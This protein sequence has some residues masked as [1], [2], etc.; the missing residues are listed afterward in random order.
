[1]AEVRLYVE[2]PLGAGQS[3]PLTGD[4]AHYLFA[5]MRMTVGAELRVFN[6]REGEW[7][8]R[9]ADAGR[10]A[11]RLVCLHQTRPLRLPPDLWLLFAPLKKAR[12]DFVVEKATELGVARIC[13]VRTDFTAAERVRVDRLRA[14]AVEATEQCGGT[15]VPVVEDLVPLSTVLADWSADRILFWADEAVA[16]DASAGKTAFGWSGPPGPA[17]IL[18]GP[19]GGFS[20][21]ERDRLSRMAHLRRAGLGPRVLRAD[22]AAVAAITLWQAALGDWR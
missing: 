2:H 7:S 10:R 3:V 5:V 4:Q 21:A 18:I 16:E 20:A 1:M 8:A 22:T 17:A 6:G 15:A 11:G 9:I 14:H 12:T 13:P 19:E